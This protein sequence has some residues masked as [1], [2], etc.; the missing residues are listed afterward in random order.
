M[1]KDLDVRRG[2]GRT[3]WQ[4]L[5]AALRRRPSDP[6]KVSLLGVEATKIAGVWRWPLTLLQRISLENKRCWHVCT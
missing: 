4:V 3:P 5:L 2:I 6:T 1:D